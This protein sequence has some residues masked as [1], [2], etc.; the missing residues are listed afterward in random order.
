MRNLIKLSIVIYAVISYASCTGYQRTS[1]ESLVEDVEESKLSIKVDSIT[2]NNLSEKNKYVSHFL[3][4]LDNDSINELLIVTETP[5]SSSCLTFWK[6]PCFFGNIYLYEFKNNDW[7][8]LKTYRL[9]DIEHT[10]FV[11]DSLTDLIV[12]TSNAITGFSS[13]TRTKTFRF[14]NGDF[15]LVKFTRQVRTKAFTEL[16]YWKYDVDFENGNAS[17]GKSYSQSLIDKNGE[18]YEEKSDTTIHISIEK[19]WRFKIESD[20]YL[21]SIIGGE[22]INEWY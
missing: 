21:D 16:C 7:V 15:E 6:S 2:L 14:I 9:P 10:S 22:N 19:K 20:I 11:F 13:A 1:D 17:I 8:I 5:D 3:L 12:E 4:D 18:P